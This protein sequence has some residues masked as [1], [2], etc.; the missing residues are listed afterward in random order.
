MIDVEI[1]LVAF[2]ESNSHEKYVLLLDD[3][4][5]LVAR[6]REATI[7]PHPKKKRKLTPFN[8][9]AANTRLPGGPNVT[10]RPR[11][12]TLK[13]N[14]TESEALEPDEAKGDRATDGPPPPSPPQPS[15]AEAEVDTVEG[16][17]VTPQPL[18]LVLD[19]KGGCNT[20]NTLRRFPPQPFVT[21]EAEVDSA[22]EGDVITPQPLSPWGPEPP[23]IDDSA[24][25]NTATSQALCTRLAPEG[26]TGEPFVSGKASIVS[27]PQPLGLESTSGAN[28]TALTPTTN[29]DSPSV[30]EQTTAEDTKHG[31]ALEVS[32]A[33]LGFKSNTGSAPPTTRQ[34]LQLEI[35]DCKKCY[36]GTNFILNCDDFTE[37]VQPNEIDE[38]FRRFGETVWL[39]DRQT[40][41]LIHSF[42]WPSTTLVLRNSYAPVS[43]IR[44]EAKS[45]STKTRWPLTRTHQ[46]IILPYCYA[47]HWTLFDID[48]LRYV[49][50]QYDSLA[51]NEGR[52]GKLVPLIEERLTHAMA[53]WNN[54]DRK[55]SAET[56]VNLYPL[57]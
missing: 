17:V 1:I 56:K 47:N 29:T 8:Y 9:G 27:T 49:I 26:T 11:P 23:E 31:S 4:S 18:P 44:P 45:A 34:K 24:Q 33:N 6:L 55:W 21:E 39:G 36:Q 19:A 28:S 37:C 53:E 48:L 54:Q 52:L 22:E 16:D 5:S 50:Y 15:V 13:A 25:E 51:D 35:E 32:D 14:L 43:Q 38:F 40:M 12:S 41:P 3:L 57:L 46:R 20:D 2:S 42:N 7:A 30:P 10:T